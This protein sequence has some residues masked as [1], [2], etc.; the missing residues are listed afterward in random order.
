VGYSTSIGRWRDVCTVSG[1]H[2]LVDFD[3]EANPAI[4]PAQIHTLAK[5]SGSARANRYA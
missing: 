1:T 4:N 2:R 5:A 3:F